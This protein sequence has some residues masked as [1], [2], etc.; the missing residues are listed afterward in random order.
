MEEL[1]ALMVANLRR[2]SSNGAEPLLESELWSRPARGGLRAIAFPN[3]SIEDCRVGTRRPT[4]SDARAFKNTVSG[5]TPSLVSSM[6]PMI[7]RFF[8][9]SI[10]KLERVVK[11]GADQKI[12]SLAKLYTCLDIAFESLL[13]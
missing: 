4:V 6:S 7:L 1:E 12:W 10:S 13:I 11:L 2:R 8:S 9:C 5:T 3:V